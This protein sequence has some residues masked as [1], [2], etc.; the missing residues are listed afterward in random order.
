MKIFFL[1]IERETV[2]IHGFYPEW[3][4]STYRI[5]SFLVIAF[6]VV[7][8]FPYV[9]GSDSLAFKGVSVFVGLLFSL[10]AQSA[11]SNVIAGFALTYRRAF[12][13]GDRVKIADFT[14]DVV[15]TRL[16]VTTLRTNKNEEI[17]VPNSMIVNSHVINYSARAREKGLILHT[18]ITIGYDTPWRQ[19]HAMLLMAAGKTSGLLAKPEPFVLQTSLDDFYVAYELNVYTDKPQRMASFYSELHQNILDVFNEYGVQIMSPNYV[20]DRAEPTIVSKEHWYA[21]P[22]KPPV[23][24]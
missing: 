17:V 8:A 11:V 19:V 18:A 7:V 10:G 12:L 24:E 3:A 15:E 14:G 5:I 23:E 4:K 1:G 6:S 13:V 2:K 22:S 20:A 9:P 16:Q 21:P